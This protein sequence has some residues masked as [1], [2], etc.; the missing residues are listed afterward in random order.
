MTKMLPVI[1]LVL[2][3]VA[4]GPLEAGVA[5]AQSS[6]AVHAHAAKKAK[7][8]KAKKRGKHRKRHRRRGGGLP[9]LGGEPKNGGQPTPGGQPNG[10]RPDPGTPQPPVTETAEAQVQRLLSGRQL[11]V[12][13][14][15]NTSTK[16]SL[17]RW[18]D[19]CADGRLRYEYLST[20]TSENGSD[21]DQKVTL[22]DWRVLEAYIAPDQSWGGARIETTGEGQTYVLE[23][24]SDARGV[25]VDGNVAEVT[26]SQRC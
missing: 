22:G 1:A 3:F 24:V 9:R 23:V 8:K 15:S 13:L 26:Q 19:F 18:W 11:H 20:S 16:W 5:A 7:K 14:D 12:Y 25:R 4:S 10:G 17:D 6:G 2:A 21:Y